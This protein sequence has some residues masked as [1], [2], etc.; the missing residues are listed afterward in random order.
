MNEQ[1]SNE[2]HAAAVVPLGQRW[3]VHLRRGA[4]SLEAGQHE[5]AA[6]HFAA[7]YKLAPERPECCL[8]LGREYLRRGQLGQAEPLLRRAW[9]RGPSALAGAALARLLG[10]GKGESQPA[11]AVLA[12]ALRRHPDHPLL[13]VVQGE[14]EL[15]DDRFEAARAAFEHARALGADPT[16]VRAGLARTYN[17]E[18]IA[19]GDEAADDRAIFAFKRACDLDPTWSGPHV[20]LGV[21]FTRLG[22]RRRARTCYERAIAIEPENPVAFFNLANLLRDSG[23]LD[24]AVECYERVLDLSPEYPGVRAA[25]AGTLADQGRYPRAIDLYREALDGEEETAS[26]WDDLGLAL[27]ASGDE[28]EGERCL[29]RAIELDPASFCACCNLAALLVCQGRQA[30]AARY[31]AKA[32]A[33]DPERA[34]QWFRTEETAGAEESPAARFRSDGASAHEPTNT[35]G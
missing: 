19:C 20:N 17:A 4:R 12:E 27:I 9:E 33:I 23:D 1:R 11:R 7:A 18:G 25:L 21:A 8:A 30:E 31:A 32:K 5:R 15:E 24:G 34:K 28:D 3:Q 13:L 2:P 22:R 16:A 26:L 29:R 35:N 6:R 14:L 10:V